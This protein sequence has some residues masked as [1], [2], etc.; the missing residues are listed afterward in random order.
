MDERFQYCRGGRGKGEV[1]HYSGSGGGNLLSL[2]KVWSR[3]EIQ[4][5]ATS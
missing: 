4:D 3:F 5:I 1:L 2:S